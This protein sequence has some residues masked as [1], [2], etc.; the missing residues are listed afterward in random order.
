ME[1]NQAPLSRSRLESLSADELIKLADLYGIDIPFG[2]ERIFIIEELLIC[3]NP[4]KQPKI[5]E[6]LEVSPTYLESALLPKQYNI[7]FIDAIVR[8]P[9]W[10]FV[11]WEVKGQD[12]E[13]HENAPDFKSYCLRLIPLDKDGRE[14]KSKENSFTVSVSTEDC[15]RYLG[16]T[17]QINNDS[18]YYMI[19]L[20]VIKGD[21]E[22]HIAS[23]L[24]FYMPR[25]ISSETIAGL[26]KKDLIRLSGAPDLSVTRN[27]DRQPRLK[28]QN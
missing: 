27:T 14:P 1:D 12:R 23:S 8:D 19:K 20:G 21:C 4:D 7:S 9:L 22:I 25:L 13:I 28:R 10:I 24:P 11:F 26:N 17:E 3:S 16:I 18:S 2:L 6:E 15:A 5:T